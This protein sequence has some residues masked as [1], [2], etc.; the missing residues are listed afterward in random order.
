MKSAQINA[1]RHQDVQQV[2]RLHEIEEH[3][4]AIQGRSYLEGHFAVT[5]N[6]R[7]MGMS[8]ILFQ[9][10][11]VGNCEAVS[12][13]DAIAEVVNHLKDRCVIE[14]VLSSEG[15]A[16]PDQSSCRP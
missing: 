6:V 5:L 11:Q 12:V 4:F 16:E 1:D 8:R 9:T 15:V 13:G 7:I 10:V 2:A 14:V 3:L